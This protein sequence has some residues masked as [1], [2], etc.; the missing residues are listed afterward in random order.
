[1]AFK[2]QPKTRSLC[3]VKPKPPV[4]QVPHVLTD[5][6]VRKKSQEP[7]SGQMSMARGGIARYMGWPLLSVQATIFNGNHLYLLI[8]RAINHENPA[9]PW[10]ARA[11]QHLF[12]SLVYNE[13]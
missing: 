2:T 1:M 5:V 13:S 10:D 6:F 12:I 11:A 8:Y 3:A 9:A 7:L 4:V